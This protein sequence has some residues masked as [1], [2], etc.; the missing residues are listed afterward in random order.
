MNPPDTGDM[1]RTMPR[2][3]AP[4]DFEKRVLAEVARR[5]E[6]AGARPRL[7]FRLAFAGAGAVL[8]AAAVLVMTP[9]LRRD[10]APVSTAAR[11][12]PARDIS[13]LET[14]DYADE[15]RSRSARPR[16]TI[17]ILEQ[18]SEAPLLEIKY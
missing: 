1:L 9:V 17:Y 8:V 2:A 15:F 14:L 7:R 11:P 13:L 5:S 12:S 10:P 16:Q 6:P 3:R 18:V 4:E